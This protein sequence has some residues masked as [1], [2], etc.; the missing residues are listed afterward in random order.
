MRTTARYPQLGASRAH[1]ESFYLKATHPD[2]GLGVWIRHT[3]HRRPGEDATAS[4]WV[5]L[6]DREAG[7]PQATKRTVGADALTFPDGGYIDVAGSAMT[8]AGARGGFEQDGTVTSWDLALQDHAEPFRHLPH[9]RL[10]TA[11]LPR[12]KPLS[13]HPDARFSGTFTLGD[14]TIVLED[15]PGMVGHNWGTEHAE[16]WTWIQAGPLDGGDAPFFDLVAGR[17]RLGRWT[18]PWIGNAVL[19]LD[20]ERHRLGGLDRVRSTEITESPSGCVFA[21]AGKGV[22]VHGTVAAPPEAFVAWVYADPGGHEHHA[23]NCSVADIELR[24]VRPDTADVL[25]TGTAGAAYELGT[26]DT[27]HGVPVQP[28]GDG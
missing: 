5:T 12:T 21:L 23:L 28:F 2:G 17:I 22:T 4:V 18:T 24:V 8:P 20:G 16:R 15:W 19:A 7:A 10:Y 3:I 13:P 25:L 14:R 27:S 1:Y 9:E 11:P 26:R 6:F